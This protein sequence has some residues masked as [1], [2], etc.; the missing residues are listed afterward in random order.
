M[1]KRENLFKLLEEL[2]I[3]WLNNEKINNI[4]EVIDKDL[5]IFITVTDLNKL[6]SYIKDKD[7]KI[8]NCGFGEI[9]IR[10]IRSCSQTTWYVYWYYW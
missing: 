8:F 2:D 3:R 9:S 7:N 5:Q 6:P 10:R 4:L 1:I